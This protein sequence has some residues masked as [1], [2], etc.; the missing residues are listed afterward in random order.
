MVSRPINHDFLKLLQTKDD[1]LVQLYQEVRELVL[2]IHQEANELL[3]H[4]HAL[5][6]V[7]SI[8]DK[9]G[10]A[11]CHI[12]IYS[13]HLNLGFNKGSLLQDDHGL[14]EGTGKFI[15]HIPIREIGDLKNS[16]VSTLIKRAVQFSQ[17]EVDSKTYPKGLLVNK[18]KQ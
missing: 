5:T 6:S 10:D 17:D 2:S 12:P 18:I 4:T 13:N 1:H 14:L 11:Y 15:R 7:Y 3:Y 9:L 8:T 16:L